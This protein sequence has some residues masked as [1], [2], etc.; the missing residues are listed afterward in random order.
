MVVL[1]ALAYVLGVAACGGR[2]ASPA[3]EVHEVTGPTMG[4]RYS[5]KIAG[6]LDARARRR[7]VAAIDAELARID[8]LM[9]TWHDESEISRF[10][11]QPPGKPFPVSEETADVL[12]TA[13][14]VTEL[15]GGAFD[16]TVGALARAWGFGPKPRLPTVPTA[17]E[18]T[19]AR[20]GVGVHSIGFDQAARTVTR[21]HPE[22]MLDLSAI[23]P[24]FA[25]DRVA[26]ALVGLGHVHVLVD[27]GGEL[28]AIGR[29]PDGSAWRVGVA[30]PKQGLPAVERGQSRDDLAVTVQLA[31][32]A[33]ATSG[34]EG[35]FWVDE[36]G[37]RRGHIIDPRTGHPVSHQLASATVVHPRAADADALATALM[38]LGPVDG[39]ALAEREQLAAYFIVRG[40]NGRLD[41]QE[42]RAFTA[43]RTGRP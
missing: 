6:P 15:S 28:K 11:R 33:L 30:R 20:A 2:P 25:A 9:S 8:E 4:T 17:D 10:N 38:V 5:V 36:T 16:I 26:D 24:G 39:P 34:D 12:A 22:T 35:N 19:A 41:T 40:S 14:R 42:T 23:A 3:P 31:N 7:V 29:R 32:Q 27:I 43:L 1:L 37:A 13:K 21:L 18:L